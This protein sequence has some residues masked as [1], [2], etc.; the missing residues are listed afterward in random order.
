MT[1][2]IKTGVAMTVYTYDMLEC[3]KPKAQNG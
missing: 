1:A 2:N 3:E